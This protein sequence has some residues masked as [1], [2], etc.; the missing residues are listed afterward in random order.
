MA[1]NMWRD[2]ILRCV[3]KIEVINL[4]SLILKVS[5][6]DSYAKCFFQVSEV[7]WNKFHLKLLF[8]TPKVQGKPKKTDDI[9]LPNLKL[10]KKMETSFVE[11]DI[12]PLQHMMAPF[13]C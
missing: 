2:S 10:N 5:W 7:T 12:F 1:Y 11:W 3:E 4:S 8:I 13:L 6:A 9:E